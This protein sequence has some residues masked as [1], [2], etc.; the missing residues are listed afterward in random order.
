MIILAPGLEVGSLAAFCFQALGQLCCAPLNVGAVDVD[1]RDA[2]QRQQHEH[3]HD[4]VAVPPPD[5]SPVAR[6]AEG[7]VLRLP[8]HLL[9]CHLCT[10][11]HI[12]GSQ[13]CLVYAAMIYGS[14]ATISKNA[15]LCDSPRTCQPQNVLLFI[16]HE[17]KPIVLLSTDKSP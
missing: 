13:N 12:G 16:L 8:R 3:H 2:Q 9:L 10:G 7:G 1:Q 5:G 6:Q 14:N 11:Q 17:R 4:G 15:D